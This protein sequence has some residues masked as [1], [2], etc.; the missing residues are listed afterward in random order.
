MFVHKVW[1]GVQRTKK[2]STN[3]FWVYEVRFDTEVLTE[4]LQRNVEVLC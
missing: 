4:S 2:F 1:K 3:Y